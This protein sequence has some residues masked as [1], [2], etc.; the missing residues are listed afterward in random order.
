M[1]LAEKQ[2]DTAII[3]QAV[4]NGEEF[5][6]KAREHILKHLRENGPTSGEAL[7]ISCKN[8]DILPVKDDR[9]FGGAFL[10]LKK[11][12][13]I[14]KVDDCK[15]AR[16]H[17]TA[18]GSVYALVGA[19]ALQDSPWSHLKKGPIVP[20]EPIYRDELLGNPHTDPKP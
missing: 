5:G 6:R 7:V 3:Q 2:R 19:E 8:A 16:G 4:S 11:R 13:L 15:R 20:I 9:A 12:G 1:E 10:S 14:K 17:A 18:G